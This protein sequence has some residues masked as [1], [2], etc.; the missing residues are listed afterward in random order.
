MTSATERLACDHR[1]EA[2][3]L[4]FGENE[5]ACQARPFKRG[6][7]SNRHA[8]RPD[9]QA[10]R[11]FAFVNQG[12]VTTTVVAAGGVCTDFGKVGI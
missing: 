12:L 10:V 5:A 7:T 8:G 4:K 11:A 6:L 1:I 3:W 9:R 2:L